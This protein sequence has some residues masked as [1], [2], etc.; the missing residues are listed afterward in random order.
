MIFQQLS[1]WQSGDSLKSLCNI[2]EKGC[3]GARPETDTAADDDGVYDDEDTT[4]YFWCCAARYAHVY[5]Y[6]FDTFEGLDCVF[7]FWLN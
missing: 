5:M 7:A 4:C 3:F 6:P 1:G 2:Y